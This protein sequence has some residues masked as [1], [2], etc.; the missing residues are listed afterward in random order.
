M[1]TVD[2]LS[3]SFLPRLYDNLDDEIDVF[4]DLLKPKGYIEEHPLFPVEEIT[5]VST[6]TLQASSDSSY[7]PSD[8]ALSNGAKAKKITPLTEE[9]KKRAAYRE[10]RREKNRLAA[11]ASRERKN[12]HIAQLNTFK[13][14]FFAFGLKLGPQLQRFQKQFPEGTF[15]A[16]QNFED[17]K[18]CTPEEQQETFEKLQPIFTQVIHTALAYK[19]AQEAETAKL[20]RRIQAL[21]AENA[22]LKK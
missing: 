20:R 13:Q 15:E 8:E 12:I 10:L 3:H 4:Q 11:Q 21:Q 17:L 2:S 14:T 1:S 9:E 7:E 16:L 19:T 18:D 22:Q 6:S 5:K